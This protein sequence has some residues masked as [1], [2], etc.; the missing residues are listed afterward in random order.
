[1]FDPGGSAGGRE[2]LRGTLER[3]RER[4]RERE[5]AWGRTDI[6]SNSKGRQAE[7]HREWQKQVVQAALNLKC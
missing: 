2:K 1:V 6:G 4:E 7:P 5:K 3:E